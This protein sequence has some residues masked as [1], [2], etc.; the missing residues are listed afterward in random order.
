[1]TD[2]YR[3][4]MFLEVDHLISA[5][6]PASGGGILQTIIGSQFS[7]KPKFSP[8]KFSH[9]I[10]LDVD[11][12]SIAFEI[13]AMDKDKPTVLLAHG[14]GG[15]SESGYIKRI[16]AKLGLQGYG[17]LLINQRGSGLGMGL[18]SSLWNGGSSE[19][20]ARMI[21]YFSQRHMHLLLIGFSLSGNIL[22]KY[23]GEGRSTPP[24]LIGAMA[25]NPPV[26]LR[27]SSHIIS[28]HPS[29]WLF[30]R[31]YMRLI[32]NQM[33]ALKKNFPNAIDPDLSTIWNFDASYTVL[34]GG[35]KDLD[36]Y[37]NECSGKHYL[38]NIKTATSILCSL[39]DPF[40]PPEVFKDVSV[41]N[42]VS[43]YQPPG[44]G[45]MGYISRHQTPHGDRRWMDFVVLEWVREMSERQ[46]SK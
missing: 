31:Y 30:N 39:D 42:N 7:G 9:T 37:Y 29:C 22:L 28:T 33:R 23:L 35:Y 18:S 36:D 12:I 27:V 4:G 41:N 24:G 10:D 11:G 26:D 5:F 2:A 19:D 1:M 45:H 40:V 43:I 14:M 16:A 20:L 46:T 25:I 21:D 38:G 3:R 8:E 32:G 6:V 15:C 34:A 17:V 44:G 13:E